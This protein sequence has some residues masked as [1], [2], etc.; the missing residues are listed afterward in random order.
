MKQAPSKKQHRNN[1]ILRYAAIRKPR[2][3]PVNKPQ[4][5]SYWQY[6]HRNDDKTALT[7]NHSAVS[8]PRNDD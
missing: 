7:I 6:P 4:Q 8:A 1:A 3:A 5:T 2:Q